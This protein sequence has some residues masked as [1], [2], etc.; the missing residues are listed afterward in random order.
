VRLDRVAGR[1]PTYAIRLALEGGGQVTAQLV[2]AGQGWRRAPKRI[3]SA[4][5]RDRSPRRT[6]VIPTRSGVDYDRVR[7]NMS[8]EV[9]ITAQAGEQTEAEHEP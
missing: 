2:S 7:A 5:D 6:P 8:F 4:R 9:S 1:T 3:E